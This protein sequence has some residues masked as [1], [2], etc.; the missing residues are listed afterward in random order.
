MRIGAG[1][2]KGRRLPAVREARPVGGRLK[3]SL[4]SVLA[5]RLPGARVL[6]LFAGVGGLGLEALSRGAAHVLLVE[7]DRR[8]AAALEAWL[9]EIAD[10]GTGRVLCADVLRLAVPP[11]PFDLVFLDPPFALWAGPEAVP[12]IA[13]A[14]APLAPDGRAVL[15]IPQ[16]MDLPDDPRWTVTRRTAVASAAYVLLARGGAADS[17]ASTVKQ[18]P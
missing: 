15:K 11:G 10:P 14:V 1:R 6:D 4:F 17:P 18:T 13:A 2:F 12:L 3:T 5:P 16:R 9:A 7:K 8:A